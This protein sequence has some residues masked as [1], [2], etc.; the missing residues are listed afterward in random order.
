[1]SRDSQYALNRYK[2]GREGTS[3]EYQEITEG[4]KPK[5]EIPIDLGKVSPDFLKFVR[6][7]ALLLVLVAVAIYAMPSK[8]VPVQ[9]TYEL[10][11]GDAHEG[12]LIVTLIAEGDLP[13]HL[14]LE[15]P[16]GV[17]GDEGNGVTPHAPTGHE[18]GEDGRL[19][20][21]LA[22]KRTQDGWQLSTRGSKRAGFIYQVDLSNILPIE[23]DVRRHISTLVSGGLRAAGFEVFLQP[24][25]VEVEDITV[26][27]HNPRRIPVITPWPALVRNGRVAK[28]QTL[29]Q[30]TMQAANLANGQGY[31]SQSNRKTTNARD[32]SPNAAPVPENLLYH[33]RDLSDLNNSLLICGDLVT[34]STQ[35]RDCV[36]QLA[37]DRMWQ[38]DTHDALELVRQIARTEMGFFGDAPT[39]QITVL[40][41][42]NEINAQGGFDTYGVHT[43]SSVL[44]MMNPATTLG[45]LEAHVSSVIAHEMF[46]GWLG[47]AIPQQDLEMLWFTEGATTWYAAR[48]LQTAGIWSSDHAQNVLMSRLERDYTDSP[49][50]GEMSVATAAKGIMASPEQVRFGYAGGMNAVMALDRY[51]AQT[52]GKRRPLDGVLRTLYK[53]RNGDPLTREQ[54]VATVKNQTGIDIDPWLEEHVYNK[55]T[56][57]AVDSV[58]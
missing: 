37:T 54:F 56:L 51:L 33:P 19:V 28:T 1:M 43:G 16:P 20:K 55:S 42:A 15:F 47:E 58:L 11:L 29:A 36:I 57:P 8:V 21:P 31:R 49:H 41:A 30:N 18:I 27:V 23:G 38:F 10:D 9:L 46:H 4:P 22:V 3:V 45:D 24:V 39:P 34:A 44:I 12:T 32:K 2:A 40:L 17:F 53:S 13:K 6:V 26:T 50:F 5:T 7:G 35:A 25:G 14:D 48:M 52:S